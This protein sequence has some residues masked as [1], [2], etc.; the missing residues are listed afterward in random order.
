MRRA[1]QNSPRGTV[2]PAFVNLRE[3]RMRGDDMHLRHRQ[4]YVLQRLNLVEFKRRPYLN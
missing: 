4:Q 1:S 2:N 3:K